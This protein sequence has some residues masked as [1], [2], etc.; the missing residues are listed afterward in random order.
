M[1]VEVLVSA[2]RG[3]HPQTVALVLAHLAPEEAARALELLPA[4]QRADVAYR[5]ATTERANPAVVRSIMADLARR[6]PALREGARPTVSSGG[7]SRL[8]E[9]PSGAVS[10]L[11]TDEQLSA[12]TGLRE[13]V[14]GRRRA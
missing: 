11:F 4:E 6:V 9:L 8:G 12:T 2:L 3:E 7:A 10:F 1:D 14:R 5:V 13:G